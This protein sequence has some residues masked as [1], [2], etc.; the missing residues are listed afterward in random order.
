MTIKPLTRLLFVQGGQCF[1]CKH[2][3][4]AADASVEHLVASSNGGSNSDDN[5][6]ACCKSLNALL[7]RMSLKQKLEIVLNQRGQFKCPNGVQTK[8]GPPAAPKAT[9]RF[10]ECY[11]Q[12]VGNLKQRGNAKPRT[13]AKLKSTIAT[14]VQNKIPPYEVDA[15]VQQLQTQGV[16]SIAGSKITYA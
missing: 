14:L 8:T 15:L 7:G 5:C 9:K 13:V 16:I 2:P 12:V 3:L 10:A 11:A 4:A 6:V 1:F